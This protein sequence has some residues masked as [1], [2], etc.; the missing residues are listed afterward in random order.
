MTHRCAACGRGTHAPSG[1]YLERATGG[2]ALCDGC[3]RM[4][5]YCDCRF[6]A[7]PGLEPLR[8]DTERV[9]AEP[10]TNAELV[11]LRSEAE[12]EQDYAGRQGEWQRLVLRLLAT[13]D[14]ARQAVP[15]ATS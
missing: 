13:L 12:S 3:G 7:V 9:R 2:R 11:V 4:T 8:F 15:E 5:L 6:V 1:V 10:L 14:A